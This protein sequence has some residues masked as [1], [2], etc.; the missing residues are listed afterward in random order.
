MKSTFALV[1]LLALS[2]V[3]LFSQQNI[4]LPDLDIA[5]QYSEWKAQNGFRFAASE[6][7]YRLTQ[8]VENLKKIRQFNQ[9]NKDVKLALNQFAAMSSEEFKE[10]ILLKTRPQR[11]SSNIKYQKT[12]KKAGLPDKVDWVKKGAVYA[13][14]N[15]GHCGSCWAFATI[16]G[17]QGLRYI[18]EGVLELLSAQQVT[19]CVDPI[20]LDNKVEGCG[21]G[22]AR[23]AYNYTS[24]NGIETWESYPYAN[25][26]GGVAAPCE[27]NKKDVVFYNDGLG[28]I[29]PQDVEGIKENL[30]NQPLT[31]AV[32]AS[33]LVFQFYSKGIITSNCG[34][35]LNHAILLVGYD[36]TEET[37]YWTVQNSWG[38]T[39]G[40]K[41][42]GKIA[43]TE[44]DG[45]CGIN[46]QVDYPTQAKS[47]K[48]K[49]LIE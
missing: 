22:E 27:Y 8:F 24:I 5:E 26:N 15:Q 33:A 43:I 42:F 30:A 3:I 38:T 49:N 48:N 37:P 44:G 1:G 46:M 19:S 23:Y 16:G 21:G 6:D 40:E 45:V 41:G 29:A 4:E 36:L 34:T 9:E 12:A 39:W 35:D 11:D 2:A 31:I 28:E 14:Q 7:I 17:L 47:S 25:F 20:Y 13:T 18:N 10:Q 32:D